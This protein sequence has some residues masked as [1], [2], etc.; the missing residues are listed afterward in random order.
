MSEPSEGSRDMTAVRAASR[1]ARTAR[2]P[3]QRRKSGSLI[4]TAIVVVA[5]LVGMLWAMIALTP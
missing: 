5:V 2:P 4:L 1:F 3:R